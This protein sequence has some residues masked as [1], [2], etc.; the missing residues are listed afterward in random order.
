M[1]RYA[2]SDGRVKI[3]A[4][5]L[6]EQSGWKGRSLGP[7]AVHERQALVLVNKGGAR[8]ADIVALCD[9]V[10]ADVKSRFGIDLSPEVNFVG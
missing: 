2:L 3:P 1:P 7:A 8:A 10:R 9:A 5:W 6:I 4:G